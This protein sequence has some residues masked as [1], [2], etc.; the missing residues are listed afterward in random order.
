MPAVSDLLPPDRPHREKAHKVHRNP[1]QPAK[2][3]RGIPT[4][5]A[6]L[7]C[8]LAICA[9]SSAYDIPKW[10]NES[11]PCRQLLFIPKERQSYPDSGHARVTLSLGGRASPDARD[12]R[13][14]GP[15]G[16]GVP[17]GIVHSSPEG[18][19][20][21]VFKVSDKDK[22]YAVYFGNR[23]AK[24]APQVLPRTGLVLETRAIPQETRTHDWNAAQAAIKKSDTVYG[25][26]HWPR[27]FDGYNPFGQ[28]EDY[29]YIY[30]GYLLC[31]IPGVYK[32]A[33][34]SDDASFLFLDGKLVAGWPGSHDISAGRRGE[35][36]GKIEIKKIGAHRFRY[37]GF[38]F[39][40]PK[41]VSAAWIT[42]DKKWWETIP[43]GAFG[44]MLR[45]E[46]FRSERRGAPACADF[47]A[48]PRRYC[49]SGKAR[50]VAVAFESKSYVDPKAGLLK[51]YHWLF[52]DGQKGS[53]RN[54]LH[55][56]F[57]PGVYEV[58]LRIA[59][60]KKASDRIRMKVRV[61]PIWNDLN[62]S[63]AKMGRF[64]ELSRGYDI[65]ALPTPCLLGAREFFRDA[66]ADE[67]AFKTAVE[68]DK[69]R[70]EL[71]PEQI[72]E[73][74]LHLGAYYHK[75]LKKNE[76]A[77]R[78]FKLAFAN[79]G[80]D[81]QKQFDAR[82]ALADHYLYYVEK[83][84]KAI[85]VYTA[86]RED[87]PNAN[88]V[89]RRIALIRIGDAHRALGD[90]KKALEFYRQAEQDAAY[91]LDQPAAIAEGRFAAEAQYYIRTGEGGAALERIEKLF[92][93]YPS[94]KL[95]GY[96]AV[97]RV[98][99]N[100]VRKDYI[101]A[102]KQARIYL[103]F[104]KEPD[105]VPLLLVGAGEACIELGLA[106]EARKHFRRVLEQFPESPAVKDA[107]NGMAR[108]QG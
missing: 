62:F 45:A 8:T 47:L 49:E 35:H 92:W 101:E 78:Y 41:R 79:A 13:V 15:N 48:R 75:P 22:L 69:R 67:K 25:K 84:Q 81:Q 95:A 71:T 54:P 72:Y 59:S 26:D 82:F 104:A 2:R 16:Q 61:E 74:A 60:T 30:T 102:R 52:G 58:E 100:L 56:Y 50:M 14:V 31:G 19:H 96:P 5:A 24:A 29:I 46:M 76:I 99:A 32:F 85:P 44:G 21:I 43:A 63:L 73:V 97:L 93:Y 27:V 51:D 53:G 12:L 65:K 36:S 94:K 55:V 9:E 10:W 4:A 34:V 3:L 37:V 88:P 68:L 70:K 17:F 33:T 64:L 23:A 80:E 90:A 57:A 42:P 91:R 98:K 105:Y 83:P 1:I 89:D 7:L 40:A 103:K 39:G 11:W 87:Y 107:E 77:E 86:M 108:L 18:V 28:Q 106:D 20:K 38:A 66:E 6:L